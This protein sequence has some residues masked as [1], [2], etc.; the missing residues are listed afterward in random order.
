VQREEPHWL[1]KVEWPPEEEADSLR[2]PL[3][4]LCFRQGVWHLE[5]DSEE[6]V[7]HVQGHPGVGRP[8]P[9]D[10]TP[11]GVGGKD[12]RVPRV[13]FRGSQVAYTFELFVVFYMKIYFTDRHHPLMAFPLK[14][15]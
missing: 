9:V 3:A 15:I 5:G 7:N 10:R 14:W 4:M 8:G 6:V 2:G 1:E 11:V 13:A 12:V